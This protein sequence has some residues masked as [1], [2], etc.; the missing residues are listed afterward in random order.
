M[1][2]WNPGAFWG[3][4]PRAGLCGKEEAKV[5][6]LPG[7]FGVSPQNPPASDNTARDSFPKWLFVCLILL[8]NFLTL[9]VRFL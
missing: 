1:R 9:P 7:S 4:R 5:S 6:L 8:G 3:L 2:T